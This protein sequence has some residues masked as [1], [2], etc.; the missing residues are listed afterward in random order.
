MCL[1]VHKLQCLFVC[2][3]E[4]IQTSSTSDSL[5]SERVSNDSGTVVG[6]TPTN[7]DEQSMETSS[8][9]QDSTDQ[10]QPM[11]TAPP[12]ATT[13]SSKPKKK[14]SWAADNVLTSIQYFEIDE[15]ERGRCGKK[16]RSQWDVINMCLF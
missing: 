10:Q 4:I 8:V 2:C 14:V 7:A 3:C 6:D 15:S 1:C 5:D 12:V 9:S 16:G 11:E 13:L